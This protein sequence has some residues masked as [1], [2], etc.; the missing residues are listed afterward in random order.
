MQPIERTGMYWLDTT[1]VALLAVG[2]LFGAM[3]GFLWQVAR[4]A[5][6]ALSLYAAIFLNDWATHFVQD[7]LLQGIDP[8]IVRALAY[9]AVFVIVYLV[10][11]YVVWLLDQGIRAVNLQPVDRL[12]GAATGA[13]KMGLLL[14]AV[15][16]GV[17]ALDQPVSRTVMEKSQVA[18][19]LAESMEFVLVVIPQDYKTELCSGLKSLRDF[20]R[21]R[22]EQA[23]S[24]ISPTADDKKTGSADSLR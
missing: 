2:A 1:I 5:S 12:L 8:G 10:L 24:K 13:C 14:A 18:P 23:R 7:L 20:A 21:T 3:S 15:C 19:V 16:L 6:V 9:L 11:Y 22:M 4:I 17:T